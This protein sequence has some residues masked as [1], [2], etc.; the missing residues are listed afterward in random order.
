[1]NSKVPHSA[2]IAKNIDFNNNHLLLELLT[3]LSPHQKYNWS[4]YYVSEK[5]SHNERLV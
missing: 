5:N 3:M 4:N 2:V 1:M